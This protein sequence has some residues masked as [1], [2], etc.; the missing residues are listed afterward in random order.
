MS[1]KPPGDVQ[2][3][4]VL[5]PRVL[6]RVLLPTLFIVVSAGLAVAAPDGNE[7]K[8]WA[9]FL[10]PALLL[11]GAAG[12]ILQR[13][14]VVGSTLYQRGTVRWSVP[15]PAVDLEEVT[16]HHESGRFLELHRTLRL[17]RRGGIS[18]LGFS[19]LW[20]ANTQALVRWLVMH[21]TRLEGEELVWAVRTDEKTRTR[22]EPLAQ[23]NLP[24]RLSRED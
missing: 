7:D 11:W 19:F 14:V 5:R 15:L 20:W 12:S 3:D 24:E 2:A 6:W 9:A 4:A 21:C 17:H 22:L 18:S 8:D 13:A 10:L 23:P 1:R 16:L